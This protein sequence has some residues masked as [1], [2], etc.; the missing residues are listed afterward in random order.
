LPKAILV[1]CGF[2]MLRNVG[3]AYARKPAADGNDLTYVHHPE[4]PH[5][6]IQMTAHSQRCLEVTQELAQPLGKSLRSSD[7]PARNTRSRAA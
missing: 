4:L 3:H 5:G 1:T 2:D 7:Q 6:F